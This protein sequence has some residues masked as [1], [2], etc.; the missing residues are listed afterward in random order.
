M[1]AARKTMLAGVSMTVRA[2]RGAA[3]LYDRAEKR[4]VASLAASAIR[5]RLCSTKRRVTSIH[6]EIVTNCRVERQEPPMWREQL[7]GIRA[8]T[9][10]D[11]TEVRT[12][13]V[14]NVGLTSN[15]WRSLLS[16]VRRL[17]G[18]SRARRAL[19]R[20]DRRA[21]EQSDQGARERGSLAA[22]H[23]MWYGASECLLKSESC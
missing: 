10:C 6:A 4:V 5:G 22:P 9:D 3:Q 16:D 14:A 21:V 13:V 23:W 2:L 19:P 7:E 12:P 11:D 8:M 18:P 17:C 20:I 1:F 15:E